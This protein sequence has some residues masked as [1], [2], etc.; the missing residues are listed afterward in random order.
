VI[1]EGLCRAAG[2]FSTLRV[3]A[4]L[5]ENQLAPDGAQTSFPVVAPLR[6][7]GAPKNLQCGLFKAFNNCYSS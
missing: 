4:A 1:I 3:L 6:R 7:Q 5:P 2:Y